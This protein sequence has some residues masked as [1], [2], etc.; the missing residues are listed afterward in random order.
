M[1][2]LITLI[3]LSI[4]ASGLF[5][6]AS[7]QE[8]RALTVDDIVK[9]NRITERKISDDGKYISVI[10]EPWKG[11]AEAMLFD[12]KGSSLFT[13]DSVKGTFFTPDGEFYIVHRA[14]KKVESLIIFNT[15][16][17]TKERVDSVSKFRLM[18]EW[19]PWILW[20]RKDSTLI[21]SNLTSGNR[22]NHGKVKEWVAADKRPAI[23]T[24]NGDVITLISLL[25]SSNK[26]LVKSRG[27]KRMAISNDAKN[28]AWI[29]DGELSICIGSE[30]IRKIKGGDSSLPEGWR[31]PDN[32]QLNFSESGDRLYFGTAP[33]VR[34]RDTSAVNGDWPGVQVWHWKESV[35]FTVQVV[36]KEREKKRTYLAVY[37]IPTAVVNQL[38]TPDVSRVLMSDKGDGDWVLTLSDK[39]YSLE[40]MWTGRSKYDVHVTNVVLDRSVSVAKEVNGNPQFSPKGRWVYWYSYPDSSWFVWSV[41]SM[42]GRFVT[43]PS[44]LPV[45]DE[46]NDVPDW[47]S[48]YGLA[49]WNEDESALYLY[50]KYDIWK[51]DPNGKERALRI[52]MNGRERGYTYRLEKTD[53]EADFIKEDS[54]ILISLFDNKTKEGGF[55]LLSRGFK[56]EP[57]ILVK[58]QY[59][60]SSILK[61]KNSKD[62]VF[63]KENFE[64]SPDVFL[65]DVSFKRELKITDINPQQ[66]E[67]LWGRAELVTW[68]S[69]DG[70][71]LQGVVYKPENF[72]PSKKY[73]MIVNFYDKNSSSLFAY[74]T[75]EAHRSTVDYHM[76]NSHGY[77]IFNPDIVYKDGY[78]GESAFNCIMPGI[79]SLIQQGWVNEKAI[80]AQGHSWGGYQVAYLAT[81]TSLFAAIESGAPVVN[82]FSAY[83]G[84]RWGTGLNRSFQYE[85]QQS[86]I[87]A[88]PWESHQRYIENSPLFAMDKVTTPILIMHNDQDGHVPWYQGIEYFVA[89]K[90]LSKPVWLLNYSGEVHWPQ[91]IQ[92]KMD[93]QKR[94]MQFF[95]HYLLGKEAPKW[96]SEGVTAI[97]LDYELGY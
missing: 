19:G 35:Q 60:Y 59:S 55:A 38:S 83:G 97:D 11:T 79:S 82:M 14:G 72:D 89:L 46:E 31:I 29:A 43:N 51:V 44:F 92:N 10:K 18:D 91:K 71:E 52:T 41:A 93:F 80:G 13:A 74:R 27:V 88:T 48:S 65:S 68:K 81:R 8:R 7:A 50:D 34:V 54:D 1:N 24:L 42:E 47:P 49:G 20:S 73:P 33:A 6:I 17:G 90:R 63:T 9:W 62:I 85:H 40:E 22:I 39:K 5:S 84:I 70:K 15:K 86:R 26:E 23:L 87:G 57:Q 45:N 3:A 76:Y 2:R 96:M 94:M 32:S 58:G 75:P 4:I 53:R 77:I 30:D 16:S 37:D 56:K 25:D 21:S 78:P 64:T 61:A 28:F 69:L 66:K 95:D 12:R 36:E 67:F